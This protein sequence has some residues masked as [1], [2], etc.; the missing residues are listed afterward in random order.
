MKQQGKIE[1]WKVECPIYD[2]N[3]SDCEGC[4]HVLPHRPT[5][6]CNGKSCIRTEKNEL[7]ESCACVEVE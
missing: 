4:I 2:E 5:Y 6:M 3:S 7:S 1:N